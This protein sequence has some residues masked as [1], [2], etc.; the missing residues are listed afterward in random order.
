MKLLVEFNSSMY[1]YVYA[2][3]EMMPLLIHIYFNIAWTKIRLNNL[4]RQKET[5]KQ[6]FFDL[7]LCF[8][9]FYLFIL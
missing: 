3:Y 6:I 7:H 1:L 2:I 8:D 5:S 4:N 9:Q